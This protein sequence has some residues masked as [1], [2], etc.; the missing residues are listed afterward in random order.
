MNK[1]NKISKSKGLNLKTKCYILLLNISLIFGASAQIL[2]KENSPTLQTRNGINFIIP[3]VGGGKRL[4]SQRPKALHFIGKKTSLERIVEACT[5]FVHYNKTI[6]IIASQLMMEEF[7]N[8]LP[9]HPNYIVQQNKIGTADAV[10]QSFDLINK[11]FPVSIVLWGDSP[12]VNA[13]DIEKMNALILSKQ[14]DYVSTA[15][16]NPKKE[17]RGGKLS[18]LNKKLE[19]ENIKVGDVVI[20]DDITEKADL[21]ENEEPAILSNAGITAFNTGVLMKYIGKIDNQ[22]A[23]HEYYLPHFIKL[24]KRFKIKT[25]VLVAEETGAMGFNTPE[26]LKKISLLFPE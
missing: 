7:K 8:D 6:T 18:I 11:N 9:A 20:V 19:I 23:E 2:E 4:H 16:L 17:I 26:E 22:N 24:S 1:A 13:A 21:K 10:R 5:S 12:V 14:C 15:V 25:C 3:A